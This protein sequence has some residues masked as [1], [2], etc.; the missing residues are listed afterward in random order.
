MLAMQGLFDG[1]QHFAGVAIVTSDEPGTHS[2]R[3]GR[4]TALANTP[5][6]SLQL[7]NSSFP[8]FRSGSPYV[9]LIPAF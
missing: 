4:F 7:A 1:L 6:S 9:L 8:H 3:A 2:G 5:T